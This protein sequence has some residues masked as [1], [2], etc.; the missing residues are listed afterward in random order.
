MFV[1]TLP[2]LLLCINIVATND[3]R[4]GFTSG[5]SRKIYS[6]I[7]EAN[8]ALWKR[9]DDIIV[10]ASHNEIITAVFVTD[11]R[12]YKDGEAVVE[13]GGVGGKS[14]TIGLR[15]PSILRGYRF[16][17]EV[18]AENPNERYHSKGGVAPAYSDTQFARK[19]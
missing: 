17:I 10:N 4:L 6:E 1:K 12:E 13:S 11:L 14:V 5:S 7:K 8:P 18:F 19:Y 3:I 16:E 15:S 9:T 2:L